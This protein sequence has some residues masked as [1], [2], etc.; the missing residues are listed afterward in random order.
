MIEVVQE[1][2]STNA[3]LLERLRHG[4]RVAEGDWFVTLRQTAGRGRQGRQWFDGTGNFMGSTIVRIADRDPPAHSLALMTGLAVYEAV[5]PYCTDPQQLMLKWPNDLLLRGAKLCGVLLEAQGDA[6]VVGI[7]V[8]LAAKPDLPDRPTIALKDVTA[9]P[10][11]ETFAERLAETFAT[12][13]ERWRTYGLEPL[14]RRWSAVATP[15]GTALRVHEP[16]GCVVEGR[17]AALDAQGNLQ[18]RLEDGTVRAIHAGD[19]MLASGE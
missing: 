7:G 11:P 15:D 19:V 2:G 16:D 12:E 1:T 8:N 14:I 6:V 3:D 10:A 13:L 17:F 9:P 18:L 4:E 5:L